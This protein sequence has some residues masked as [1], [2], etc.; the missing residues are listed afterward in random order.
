MKAKYC[1]F[2]ILG[3]WILS[4]HLKAYWAFFLACSY[5]TREQFYPFETC[6][7]R[8][9]G[10]VRRN[11][12]S[13]A[14]FLLQILLSA[15]VLQGLPSLANR[16]LNYFQPSMNSGKCSTYCC[17]RVSLPDRRNFLVS[18][19]QIETEPKTRKDQS[20]CLK[21]SACSSLLW[22]SAP[23]I[24]GTCSS[25]FLISI[26]SS[27]P[28]SWALWPGNCLWAV[29]WVNCRAHLVIALSFSQG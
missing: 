21:H 27:R 28:D 23:K 24:L 2:Y 1:E 14:N 22:Y 12:R 5:V 15:Q 3:Y 18:H 11:Y 9:T 17:W 19:V 7:Q 8:S 25:R 20:A 10:W 4:Y 29:S 26:S 6:L 13:S 16:N